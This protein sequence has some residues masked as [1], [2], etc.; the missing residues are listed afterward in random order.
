[1]RIKSILKKVAASVLAGALLINSGVLTP[2]P[3]FAAESS[4]M[5]T[6]NYTAGA[7]GGVT[8]TTGNT[9][10]F[11][12]Y[13][14][15]VAEQ[16]S[17]YAVLQASQSVTSGQ[18]PGYK[19]TKFGNGADYKSNID[20][21]DISNYDDKMTSLYNT[22]KSAEKSTSYGKGLYL[23]S[24][25]KLGVDSSKKP[26]N[27]TTS[28][29]YSAALKKAANKTNNGVWTGTYFNN[30]YAGSGY[31]KHQAYV[32]FQ[33]GTIVGNTSKDYGYTQ[34]SSLGIAPVFN[35]DTSKVT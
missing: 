1:M 15:M 3:T 5:G 21:Q 35:L 26:N 8:L 19:M 16:G 11:G 22:I 9:Y 29:N 4:V 27:A 32:L 20:G 23:I 7:K 33:S 31:S 34:T 6:N 12:G 13:S 10:K 2:L 30:Y 25:D 17:G 24:I 28:G 18:W 14:W